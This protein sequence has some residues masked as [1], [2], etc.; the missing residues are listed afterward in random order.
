MCIRDRCRTTRS[1]SSLSLSL[2]LSVCAEAVCALRH[3][4]QNNAVKFIVEAML[5]YP[6]FPE[7]QVPPRSLPN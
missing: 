4:V 7:L 1:S 5:S 2:S 3:V 6:D